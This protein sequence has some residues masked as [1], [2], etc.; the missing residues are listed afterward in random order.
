MLKHNVDIRFWNLA[1]A[2]RRILKKNNPFLCDSHQ[3]DPWA[4]I[5]PIYIPAVKK[6]GR[7]LVRD[8][9][10]IASTR[11]G[12]PMVTVNDLILGTARARPQ[13]NIYALAWKSHIPP[14]YSCVFKCQWIP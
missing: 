13:R 2:V 7:I 1:L 12:S 14:H 11:N 9:C 4:L 5:K 8:I 3:T 6:R 10:K